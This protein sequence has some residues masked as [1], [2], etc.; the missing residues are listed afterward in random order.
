MNQPSL[1]GSWWNLLVPQSG[2][3]F[4][5]TRSEKLTFHMEWVLASICSLLTFPACTRTKEPGVGADKAGFKILPCL[6]PTLTWSLLLYITLNPNGYNS[7][8]PQA[9]QSMY[10][11]IYEFIY[12]STSPSI[13]FVCF[14]PL[15]HTSI[16]LSITYVSMYHPSY[17]CLSIHV[18]IH[19]VYSHPSTYLYTHLPINPSCLFIYIYMPIHHLYIFSS[20]HLPIHPP[21]VYVSI[22][23]HP[24]INVCY[25]S[26]YLSPIYIYPSTHRFAISIHPATNLPTYPPICLSFS[27]VYLASYATCYASVTSLS[28]PLSA[29]IFHI[30]SPTVTYT[31]RAQFPLSHWLK[32]SGGFLLMGVS[33]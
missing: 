30:I 13:I 6:Q 4:Y 17:M 32:W 19:Y 27:S 14:H 11:C 3:T 26:I 9:P 7:E 18:C 25:A 15:F 24:I 29:H 10:L 33:L 1:Q 20:I 8:G 5:Y 2:K 12:S 28:F 21:S 16:Y 31:E 23:L 22:F